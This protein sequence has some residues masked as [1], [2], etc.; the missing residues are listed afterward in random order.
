MRTATKCTTL[1]SIRSA[2]PR[3]RVRR[4]AQSTFLVLM[5]LAGWHECS[6]RPAFGDKTVFQ[7]LPLLGT[8]PGRLSGPRRAPPATS[9]AVSD[10]FELSTS[11]PLTSITWCARAAAHARPAL[12]FGDFLRQCSGEWRCPQ[13]PRQH[14]ILHSFR[15]ARLGAP[16]TRSIIRP[17]FQILAILSCLKSIPPRF[18]RPF[19]CRQA[20]SIG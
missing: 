17:R 11:A 9:A 5:A 19:P 3:L 13:S 10:D 8:P 20:R 18:Q 14:V 12:F 7:Q 16:G 2:A 4:R 6:L 1:F 15:S